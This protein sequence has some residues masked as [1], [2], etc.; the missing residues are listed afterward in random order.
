MNIP[1]LPELLLLLV[2]AYLTLVAVA[3]WMTP[4]PRDR[5]L[6]GP[7]RSAAPSGGVGRYETPSPMD[8]RPAQDSFAAPTPGDS[9]AA[10]SAATPMGEEGSRLTDAQGAGLSHAGDPRTEDGRG[11]N[12]TPVGPGPRYVDQP[13]PS[14]QGAAGRSAG[15]VDPARAL[16]HPMPESLRA[17]R[18]D[19]EYTVPMLPPQRAKTGM[20]LIPTQVD[21]RWRYE[22]DGR[23]YTDT[24]RLRPVLLAL[25]AHHKRAGRPFLVVVRIAPEMT[26]PDHLLASLHTSGIPFGIPL[27]NRPDPRQP[28]ASDPTSAP[29]PVPAPDAT[30]APEA[31]TDSGDDH[32]TGRGE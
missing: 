2:I 6:Q 21:G 5:A 18:T 20:P 26:M 29:E 16:L 19:A 14:P 8:A 3:K 10:P 23:T 1:K 28:T 13:P 15:P 17:P 9:A 31:A 25:A 12:T 32:A 22:F 4:M 11:A 24:A 7:P 27:P 30:P